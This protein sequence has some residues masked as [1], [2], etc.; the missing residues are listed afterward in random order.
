MSSWIDKD[1]YRHVAVQIGGKR[2]HRRL[3]KG[4]S[5]RDAKQLEA[6]LRQAMT[7]SQKPV[8]PGDPPMHALLAD[9]VECAKRA[10]RSP[11]TAEHHA[12]R[13]EPWAE[14]YRASQ[15][16]ECA[17]HIIKDMVGH[18]AAATI[19]RSLGTLKKSLGARLC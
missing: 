7:R 9:Y 1:G 16:R 19:N 15:A 17:A 14:K 3:Q 4:S 13:I 5:A 10:Q 18:Y 8:I 11:D 2:V 12:M 6:E